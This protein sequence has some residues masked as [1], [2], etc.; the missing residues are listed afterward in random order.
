MKRV[1]IP[2]LLFAFSLGGFVAH[3]Q[4]VVAESA[5]T[6]TS[7]TITTYSLTEMDYSTSLYYDAEADAFLWQSGSVIQSQYF[8]GSP[9]ASGSLYAAAIAGDAYEIQT[10]HWV[11]PIISIGMARNTSMTTCTA[12]A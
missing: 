10:N 11:A 9:D 1:S 3:A 12:I 8:T 4:N 7:G 2:V 6:L 5:I